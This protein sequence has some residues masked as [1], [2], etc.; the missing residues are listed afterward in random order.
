MASNT[1]GDRLVTE[2]VVRGWEVTNM[3]AH[4]LKE[5]Y[6]LNGIPVS[7]FIKN[8]GAGEFNIVKL[9]EEFAKH[10]PDYP[11]I[12]LNGDS[13]AAEYCSKVLYDIGPQSRQVKKKDGDKYWRLGMK[14]G[15][16]VHG[17][18]IATYKGE[19][20]RFVEQYKE[21]HM[22]MTVRQAGLIAQD[23]L[24]EIVPVAA[25]QSTPLYLY[26]P[27]SGACF[28]KED[29]KSFA[30]NLGITASDLVTAVNQ[31]TQSGGHYL[32]YSRTSIAVVASFAATQNMKDENQRKSIVTKTLKQYLARKK[33]MTSTE[34][35]IAS[36][37]CTGGIPKEF[38]YKKLTDKYCINACL[39]AC[40]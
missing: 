13:V 4:S 26:T 3:S 35:N 36:R 1:K 27:L 37:Y 39:F 29:V 24:K 25:G 33:P 9:R 5:S 2:E 23:I 16:E 17:V 22:V 8:H 28:S 10:C 30:K 14:K 40:S 12:V 38:A 19:E 6:D 34:F 18:T 21:K 32:D 20:S 11:N 7:D 31:S 15:N